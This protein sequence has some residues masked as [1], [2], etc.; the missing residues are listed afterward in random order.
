MTASAE[1]RTGPVVSGTSAQPFRVGI[2][3]MTCASCVRRVERAL[4]AVP[5]VEQ[6]NVNLATEEA[7]V[8]A[9]EVPIE[10]LRAA[11]DRAGYELRLADESNEVAQDAL[12]TERRA[13]YAALK[14]RTIF[15]LG[16]AA[17]LMGN[18][19]LQL[20]VPDAVPTRVLF[21]IEFALA[22]PVQFW[23]GARF[24]QGAWRIGRHGS[25][26]MNTLIALGTSVAFVYSSVVTFVPGVFSGAMVGGTHAVYFDTSA[27]IIGF[28]LLGRTMEARAKGQTS[29]AVRAL[30]ALRPKLARVLEDGQEYEIPIAAVQPG[31][32]VIVRPGEQ[33]PVDGEVAAGQSAVDE[34]M[35]TGE[36][37]PVVKGVGAAV[38]GATV[39]STGV[40]QLRATAVGADSALARIIRL[41]QDAQGSKAPIQRLADQIAAVFVPTVIGIAALTFVAWFVFGPDPALTFATLNA[42][43][44][45]IIACPCALGLATPTAIMVGTGRAGQAGVL[46]RDAAALERSMSWCWT[47]PAPSPRA[48]PQ[49]HRFDWSR[50]RRSSKTRSYASLRPLSADPSTRT[51]RRSSAR[52]SVEKLAS[53]GR[54]RSRR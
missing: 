34:S 28:I 29:Q 17:L 48:T 50:A 54:T 47:R 52:Q 12:E 5:G 1:A 31:D 30:I 38:F 39:N 9:H 7:S 37:A 35:L 42:V 23:A 46:V 13:E 11:V 27:A 51:P 21:P 25:S 10:S 53:P 49:S 41:V 24:Y 14:Q 44:V 22:L 15:A 36:S 8:V 32:T 3:G 6:A 20:I 26:D 18:M 16:V 4:A 43:A 40:L 33:I 45:L 2:H 19:L